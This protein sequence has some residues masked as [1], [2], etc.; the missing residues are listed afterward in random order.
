MRGLG[1]TVQAE[2]SA[3]TV[4]D[5]VLG[6]E[7]IAAVEIRRQ[8]EKYD[9]TRPV[10]GNAPQ[11]LIAVDLEG[12]KELAADQGNLSTGG[13]ELEVQAELG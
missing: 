8:V 6:R 11:C 13:A 1:R 4:S 7:R 9:E 12:E 5:E 2:P 10:L 3:D